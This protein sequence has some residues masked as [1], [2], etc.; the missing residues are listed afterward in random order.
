[1]TVTDGKQ[2]ST[3]TSYFCIQV[4]SNSKN[5][6]SLCQYLMLNTA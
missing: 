6:R 3:T 5:E 4:T 2:Y 1:M